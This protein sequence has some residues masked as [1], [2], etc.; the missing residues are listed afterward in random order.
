MTTY[1]PKTDIDVSQSMVDSIGIDKSTK[2]E[3]DNDNLVLEVFERYL[4]PKFPGYAKGPD[5]FILPEYV[6]SPISMLT[7]RHGIEVFGPRFIDEI[8]SEICPLFSGEIPDDNGLKKRGMLKLLGLTMI[9]A[10]NNYDSM[11]AGVNWHIVNKPLDESGI[12]NNMRV[13]SVQCRKLFD[14]FRWVSTVGDIGYITNQDTLGMILI[15]RLFNIFDY[16]QLHYFY[17]VYYLIMAEYDWSLSKFNFLY[18][19]RTLMEEKNHRNYYTPTNHS[20]NEIIQLL[21]KLE[22]QNDEYIIAESRFL[23]ERICPDGHINNMAQ[24]IDITH[25]L[26]IPNTNIKELITSIILILD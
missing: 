18:N 12:S 6:H 15:C 19:A 21:D 10:L 8:T 2:E 17:M 5:E 11:F 14:Y 1:T 13:R 22:K 24:L 23:L 9:A 7:Y 25:Y 16:L 20:S 3:L 4:I 26:S